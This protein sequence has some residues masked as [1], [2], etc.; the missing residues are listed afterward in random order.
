MVDI[1]SRIK[2]VEFTSAWERRVVPEIEDGLSA[3]FI[4]RDDLLAAKL[5]AGRPRQAYA[6]RKLELPG[7]GQ[8]QIRLHL[9]WH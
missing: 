4:S 8:T 3:P 9:F 5:A 6:C 2:G 7:G 1:L